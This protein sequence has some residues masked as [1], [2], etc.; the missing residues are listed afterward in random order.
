MPRSLK[1]QEPG[2]KVDMQKYDGYELQG[3]RRFLMTDFAGKLP[4][5]NKEFDKR[6]KWS[7]EALA[8]PILHISV[9]KFWAL[10]PKTIEA[11]MLWW[12]GGSLKNFWTNHN[13]EVSKA[14]SYKDYH[15]VNAGLLSDNVDKVKAY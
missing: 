4:N 5:A 10:H 14:T 2:L 13:S 11:Y 1:F 8:C 6:N 3:W 9:I 7:L 15:L 12:N